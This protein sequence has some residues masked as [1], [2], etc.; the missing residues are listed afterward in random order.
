MGNVS[1]FTKL[2]FEFRYISLCIHMSKREYFC[3]EKKQ[4]AASFSE[5]L[6]AIWWASSRTAGAALEKSETLHD[7]YIE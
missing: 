3:L 5:T 1:E 2:C 7:T 6:G 4:K